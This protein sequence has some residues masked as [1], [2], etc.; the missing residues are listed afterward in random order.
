MQSHN[1][2]SNQSGY[3]KGILRYQCHGCRPNPQIVFQRPRY[4]QVALPHPLA[5][6]L[7]P[8]VAINHIRVNHQPRRATQQHPL[9]AHLHPLVSLECPKGAHL[10]P[11]GH[12]RETK[13]YRWAPLGHS[14]ETKGAHLYPL[15]ALQHLRV[16]HLHLWG[17]RHH[18][19]AAQLHPRVFKQSL[20]IRRWYMQTENQ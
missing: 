19:H 18:C 8:W 6:P 1:E 17:S 12:S 7:H 20:R 16:A 5:T 15:A 2:R 9:L 4:T 11:L 14:R 3:M 13:G 10:Y